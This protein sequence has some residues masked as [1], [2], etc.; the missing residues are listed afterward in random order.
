M[1][2]IFARPGLSNLQSI[3]VKSCQQVHNTVPD[4]PRTNQTIIL[5]ALDV[6]VGHFLG[7]QCLYSAQKEKTRMNE[8]Q[9][10]KKKNNRIN[11]MYSC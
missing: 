8:K 10:K 2:L 5:L 6:N 9:N 4:Y 7:R 11:Y 3:A 1:L